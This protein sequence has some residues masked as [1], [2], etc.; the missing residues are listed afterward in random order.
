MSVL[1]SFTRQFCFSLCFGSSSQAVPCI[2][3]SQVVWD[4]T[5]VKSQMKGSLTL[6]YPRPA[7]LITSL[8]SNPE[9]SQGA[10]CNDLQKK[11]KFICEGRK[12]YLSLKSSS[13]PSSVL[14]IDFPSLALLKC[15]FFHF[16]II[17]VLIII[18][19]Y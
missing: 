15:I 10:G 9:Y 5:R 11:G 4:L 13:I 12:V 14:I 2:L 8:N 3:I 17:M 18:C 7:N 19:F 1:L 16:W 6:Q